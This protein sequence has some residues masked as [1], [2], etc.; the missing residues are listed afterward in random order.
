MKIPDFISSKFPWVKRAK[1]REAEAKRQAQMFKEIGERSKRREEIQKS[2]STSTVSCQ[3]SDSTYFSYP[4][5]TGY[6]EQPAAASPTLIKGHGGTFDGGGASGS[7]VSPAEDNHKSHS[8]YDS[9]SYNHGSASSH[10][11]HDYGSSS[12]HSSHDS[13]S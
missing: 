1:E 2:Q 4:L 11:S 12:S 13:S 3:P 6:F 8:S 9:S 10:S 7:W 5:D